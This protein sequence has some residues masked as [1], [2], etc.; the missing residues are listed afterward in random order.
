MQDQVN[1]LQQLGIRAAFLNS[2]LTSEQ[3]RDIE[4]KLKQGDID[5]LYIAPER[6]AIESTQR[7]LKTLSISLFAIDEAHCV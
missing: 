2:T 5:L 4:L 7:F 3:T 6:L 1:T